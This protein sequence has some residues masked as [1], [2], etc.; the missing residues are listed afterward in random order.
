MYSCLMKFKFIEP[1]MSYKPLNNGE[2]YTIIVKKNADHQGT[3]FF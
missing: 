1:V 3:A 2:V